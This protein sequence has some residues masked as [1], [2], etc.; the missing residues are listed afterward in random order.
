MQLQIIN[1][2]DPVIF[3]QLTDVAALCEE[4][5]PL[6]GQAEQGRVEKEKGYTRVWLQ[7]L[8]CCTPS[9]FPAGSQ[10]GGLEEGACVGGCRWRW[11]CE[12]SKVRLYSLILT[13]ALCTKI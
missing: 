7:S 13:T 11:M 2:E 4:V 3:T 6:T 9:C 1:E 8:S 5:L 10:V 12:L